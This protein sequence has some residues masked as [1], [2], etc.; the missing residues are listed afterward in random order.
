VLG[1]LCSLISVFYYLRVMYY[2][3]FRPADESLHSF[4][5]PGALYTVLALSAGGTLLLGVWPSGVLTLAQN[6]LLVH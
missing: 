6:A 2:M 3:Y 4:R 5:V 1:V